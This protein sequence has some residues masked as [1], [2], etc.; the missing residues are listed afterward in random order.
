M[1]DHLGQVGI[2]RGRLVVSNGS[3]SI[4]ATPRLF[5][6]GQFESFRRGGLV[7]R[8]EV[9]GSL[10]LFSMLPI[11]MAATLYRMTEA[12]HGTFGLGYTWFAL[13]QVVTFV[14]ICYSIWDRHIQPTEIPADAIQRVVLDADRQR[15]EIEHDDTGRA[16]TFLHG[17]FDEETLSLRSDEDVQELKELLRLA[18]IDYVEDDAVDRET[19]YRFETRGGV[20][21]CGSCGSQV[22]PSDRVC[23][24]CEYELRVEV[25]ETA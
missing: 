12:N 6:A 3:V 25:A 19:D 14:A 1:S 21:F 23:P 20:C 5:L 16:W 7:Q 13:L 17:E 8:I 15:L 11:S 2:A 10:F 22:S 9:A 24:A 4:R 18:G